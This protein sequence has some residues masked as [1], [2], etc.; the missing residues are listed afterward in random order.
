MDN[1]EAATLLPIIEEFVL[2]GTTIMTDE[3]ASYRR[4]GNLPG[5]YNHLTVNHAHNFVDPQTQAHT[6]GVESTWRKFKHRNKI[7]CG[8]SRSLVD[9]YL[10]EFMWRQR[11]KNENL[12]EKI[13]DAIKNFIPP[14]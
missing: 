9:S 11:H 8:T 14:E 10:C 5:Q 1:R 4:I 13:L 2:P 7:E 12:F 6:Q 3:W